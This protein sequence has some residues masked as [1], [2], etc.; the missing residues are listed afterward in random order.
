MS[1]PGEHGTLAQELLKPKPLDC[2]NASQADGARGPATPST[3]DNAVVPFETPGAK[4]KGL[5]ALSLANGKTAAVSAS[6][7]NGSYQPG[8][9][10]QPEKDMDLEDIIRDSPFLDLSS[11]MT[12]YEWFKLV[13][14][15]WARNCHVAVISLFTVSTSEI[16]GESTMLMHACT[17]HPVLGMHVG[18]RCRRC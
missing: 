4:S 9:A 14:M 10:Q 16:V 18:C 11:P 8:P 12:A 15:V 3:L 1:K 7:A 6:S 17:G 5:A 2:S 13:V